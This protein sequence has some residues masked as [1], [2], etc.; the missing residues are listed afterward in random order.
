MTCRF[1]LR[2][3]L[4]PLVATA[5]SCTAPRSIITSGK[6]TPVGEIRGG[7]NMIFN[8]PTATIGRLGDVAADA[9]REIDDNDTISYLK[10][11]TVINNI[12]R[13]AIAYALDPLG[14]TEDFYL[15][16]GVARRVDV[17]ARV[18]AGAFVA[19]VQYQLKGST[20]DW[21]APKGS[22]SQG[23]NASIGLVFATQSADIP[24]RRALDIGSRLLSFGARRTDILIPFTIS[25]SLGH[26]EEIGHV[27][28]GLV[29]GRS[30]IHYQFEPTKLFRER[31]GSQ[32]AELVPS[33]NERHSFMTYGGFL[34]L[35][36][37]YRFV[38]VIP[39]MAIYYQN[40]GE[41]KLL[42]DRTTTLKGATF[43]P[44]IGLQVCIPTKR[45]Q[46]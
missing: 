1:L 13:A 20:Q 8:I 28:A 44:S 45:G 3:L 2:F 15:R 46:R 5:I 9:V 12:Q 25:G 19:D 17:G 35:K 23:S 18:A 33:V 21:R 34:S 16:Y 7:T 37:G 40:Y 30:F 6:V 29:V 27:A 24:G 14:S 41:F 43:V 10:N 4:L 11:E 42:N 31:G 38:Y 36:L 26:E 22:G 39:A 32:V